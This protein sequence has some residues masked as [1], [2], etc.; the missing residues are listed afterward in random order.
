METIIINRAMSFIEENYDIDHVDEMKE[1]L[2]TQFD[3][4][5]DGGS[6]TPP[7]PFAIGAN[8]AGAGPMGGGGA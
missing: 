4:D 2:D 3:F 6:E 8:P 7:A 1:I 5:L